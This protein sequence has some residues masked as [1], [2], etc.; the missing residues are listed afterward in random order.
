MRFIPVEN[1]KSGM[2]LGKTLYGL[3]GEL[4]LRQG[5]TLEESYIQS[6]LR[7][8]YNGI[9]IEDEI[10]DGIEI[11]DLINDEL[12]NKTVQTIK[13][14][15]ISLENS[16]RLAEKNVEQLKDL[17]QNIIDELIEKQVMMVDI[18][19]LK[20]FDDYTYYHSVSVMTMATAMGLGMSLPKKE[21][22]E[23][24][25]GTML[26]DIGK[27]FVPKEILNKPGRLTYEEY[28]IMKTH[29]EKGYEYLRDRYDIPVKSYMTVYQHHEKYDGSGYPKSLDNSKI[30]PGARIAAISDVYDALTSHR[31]YRKAMLPSEAMEYLLGGSGTYFDPQMVDIFYHRVAP[32]P[33]GTCVHL[34]D[35]RT[36]IVKKNYPDL[37]LRPDIEIF[38]EDGIS[39]SKYGISLHNDSALNDVTI[40]GLLNDLDISA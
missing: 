27:M 2:I 37:C 34:S 28:D 31:P 9:Y 17:I 39:V 19:D 4:L 36:G 13:N 15:F 33:L 8:G 35:G 1:A 12:R 22:F 21:L 32:Y 26:H 40:T 23:I 6:I 30:C 3:S 5:I 29:S 10:S 24:G 7:L 25:I 20:V 38:A 16:G 11:S 18:V 14:T